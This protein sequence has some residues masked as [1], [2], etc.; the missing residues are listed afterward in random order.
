MFKEVLEIDY[1]VILTS[2]EVTGGIVN[3]NLLNILQPSDTMFK[4]FI[5]MKY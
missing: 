1:A 5:S 2:D 3:A 4:I